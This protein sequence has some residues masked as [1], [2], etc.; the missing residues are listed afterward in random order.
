MSFEILLN[1]FYYFFYTDNNK[2][3]KN[4]LTNIKIIEFACFFVYIQIE[5]FGFSRKM[6]YYIT[7]IL[8][9]IIKI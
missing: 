5:S 4:I 6:I 9:M 1:F 3:N 7:C 8:L 2:I